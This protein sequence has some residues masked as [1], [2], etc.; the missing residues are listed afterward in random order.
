MSPVTKPKSLKQANR[1]VI[2]GLLRSSGELS[3]AELSEKA[4]QSKTTV[5]KI[6]NYYV[7]QGFVIRSGKGESSEEGGKKPTLYQFNTMGGY[8]YVCQIFPDALYS[9][10]TDLDSYH[11]AGL[12]DTD[13]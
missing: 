3:I 6:I 2:L 11:I 10:V 13:S 1:K 5:M 8:V 9:V 4:K 7:E 12:Q